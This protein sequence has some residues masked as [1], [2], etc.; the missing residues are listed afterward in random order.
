MSPYFVLVIGAQHFSG[1]SRKFHWNISTPRTI[2]RKY[3]SVS[4]KEVTNLKK[5]YSR[6]TNEDIGTVKHYKA[7]YV[8]MCACLILS[9]LFLLF[10]GIKC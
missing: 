8:Y 6:T 10:L 2:R 1:T 3:H 4:N 9:S 5:I 7:S